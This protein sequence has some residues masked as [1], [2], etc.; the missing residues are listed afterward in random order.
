MHIFDFEDDIYGEEIE[1]YLLQQ[2]RSNEKFDSHDELSKQLEKDRKHIQSLEIIV[3][4][5]G[6]FDVIHQ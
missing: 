5:F 3:L 6:T 1:I 2:V 4:T